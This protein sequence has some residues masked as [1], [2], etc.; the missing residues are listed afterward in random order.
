MEINKSVNKEKINLNI[1]SD[2]LN[3]VIGMIPK[4]YVRYGITIIFLFLI[5][6]LI[7]CCFF[8]FPIIITAN[9]TITAKDIPSYV[10]AHENPNIKIGDTIFTIIPN[11]SKNYLAKVLLP[12]ESYGKV[13][14]GQ[15]IIIR[16]DNY[17]FMEYGLLIGK[18]NKILIIPGKDYY[19]AEVIFPNKLITSYKKEIS[20][21]VDLKGSAEIVI[22]NERLIYKFISP[23]KQY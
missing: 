16:L 3:E 12:V 2:E 5:A 19:I 23:L 4:W 17:P 9:V 13:K 21:L 18:I 10:V 14:I 1:R 11:G 8:K 20:L 22:Q 6:I 7:G 15:K